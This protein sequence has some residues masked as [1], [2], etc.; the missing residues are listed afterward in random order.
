[1]PSSASEHLVL[2]SRL[3]RRYRRDE[4]ERLLWRERSLFEYRAFILPTSDLAVHR[5]T[6]R[7]YPST[8]A[9]RHVYVRRYLQRERR[10]PPPRALP[11]SVARG[12]SAT[13]ELEDR[14]AVGWRTGGWNDDAA[15]TPG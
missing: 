14:S 12:R 8:E 1:M 2:W 9:A 4:L 3:G 10:V 13:R 7:R 6:M 15:A 5:E 11:D